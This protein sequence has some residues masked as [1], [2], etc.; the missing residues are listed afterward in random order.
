MNNKTALVVTTI[1]APNHVLESCAKGSI[2]HNVD[3][4]VVGDVKSPA[5]FI[6]PGSDYWSIERQNNLN[7][8]L[9]KTLPQAHYSRKNLGYLIAIER[10]SEVIIETDDDNIPYESFW[11][12]RFPFH[13]AKLAENANW[14]NVYR[15]FTET[16]IWPR[17]YPLE[18]IQNP[19]I[20]LDSFPSLECYCPIQQGLADEN[21]DVDAVYRLVNQLPI[22]FSKDISIALGNGSW[23][24]FNSQNTTWF[25]EAFPLLYIP[26]YCNFRMCDIWR[27][28]IALRICHLNEWRILFHGPTVWQDRNYHKLIN[29]FEDEIP[30]YLNNI[31]ICKALSEVEIKPG[32]EHI[33]DNLVKCYKALINIGIIGFGELELLNG[34]ILDL[35]KYAK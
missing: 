2:A 9:A 12:D 27:S 14:I 35:G 4:I 22:S 33:F 25:K 28:Y 21:P 8:R 1:S 29:D 10:G 16:N 20:S 5:D 6:L 30:G 17:G 23:A 34:W 32:H 19:T 18:Y 3:F 13:N 7:F 15:Y 24:P 11:I 31:R 26:S